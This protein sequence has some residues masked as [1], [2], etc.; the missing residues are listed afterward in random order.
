M[1]LRINMRGRYRYYMIFGTADV[2]LHTL[3]W[4]ALVRNNPM[5][6]FIL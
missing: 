5:S 1:K 6:W 3:N 4:K 2:P